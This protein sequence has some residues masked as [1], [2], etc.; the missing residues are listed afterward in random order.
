ASFD[1]I[2]M[3]L[4]S[5]YSSKKSTRMECRGPRYTLADFIVKIGSCSVGPSFKGVLVEIEYGP[6]MVPNNCWDLMKEFAQGFLGNVITQPNQYLQSNMNELYSP[7]DSIHQYNEQFN[8]L[9]KSYMTS[10]K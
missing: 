10:I 7:I 4:S 8:N 5:V 3:N 9:R 2:M 6:C 1:Q